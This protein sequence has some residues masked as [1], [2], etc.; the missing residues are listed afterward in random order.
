M[1]TS[2]TYG[3]PGGGN[4][5]VPS[6]LDAGGGPPPQIADEPTYSDVSK[7][8]ASPIPGGGSS[9][10][11]VPPRLPPGPTLPI[12]APTPRRFSAART[13]FSKFAASG[14]SDRKSLG[15]AISGYVA[16]AS[17]GSRIAA[18]RMG[19]S[20]YAGARLVGFLSDAISRG[21]NTALHSL[22]LDA[23][24]GRPV[25]EVFLG[26]SDYVC[27]NY[28][29]V[30]EAIA[31]DAFIETIADLASSGITDLNSMTGDQIQTVFE[32][33][34][35]HAIEARIC[36]DIGNKVLTFPTD[37]QAAQNVQN[38][39]R[40]FIRRGVAD[41]LT[42]SRAELDNL[43]PDRVFEF[44]EGVYESAFSVLEALGRQEAEE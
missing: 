18:R 6:W 25:E 42:R 11:P 19:A 12:P 44:V 30:D 4:P 22:N 27:P 24:A 41:A 8:P 14:G 43:T 16:T 13:N 1:G 20:R 21:A 2:S 5:L 33:Y 10:G 38:Q 26:L 28:G 17:G 15:R 7:D 32:L 3:G 23:L 31:R 35:T 37:I 40:D 9:D 39:L 34:S 36:N 29:T